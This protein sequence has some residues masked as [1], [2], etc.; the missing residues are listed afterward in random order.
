MSEILR[1]LFIATEMDVPNTPGIFRRE[2]LNYGSLVDFAKLRKN[3][4]SR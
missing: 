2:T 4:L 1:K 3:S